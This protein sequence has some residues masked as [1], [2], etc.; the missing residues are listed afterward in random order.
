MEGVDE[1][2][3]EPAAVPDPVEVLI[4]EI[5]TIEDDHERVTLA[6]RL[7]RVLTES[8]LTAFAPRLREHFGIPPNEAPP[9][10]G[11]VNGAG[12]S[13]NGSAGGAAR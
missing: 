10:A 6:D 9:P 13:P 12:P 8:R 11:F 3:G 4:R 7:A 2:P 5:D 1:A